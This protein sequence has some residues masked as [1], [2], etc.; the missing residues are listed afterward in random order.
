M[1][2]LPLFPAP[3]KAAR[4]S[5][6]RLARVAVLGG[7]LTGSAIMAPSAAQAGVTVAPD[8]TVT[9]TYDQNFVPSVTPGSSAPWLTAVISQIGNGVRIALTSSLETP[10]EF[11]GE[12]RF[13]IEPTLGQPISIGGNCVS[14]GNDAA[15]ALCG[16]TTFD[17]QENSANAPNAGGLLGFDFATIFPT[18]AAVRFNGFDTFAFDFTTT[19][20]V[21]LTPAS[22]LATTEPQAGGARSDVCTAVHLKG[23]TGQSAD[24]TAV[25]ISSANG[26]QCADGFIS[27]VPGPLPLLGV[28][29][30]FGYSR[31]IRTRIQG[32][33]QQATIS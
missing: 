29:A 24:S 5:W 19:G 18:S 27:K 21:A 20:S 23:I 31:K 6:A 4:L 11:F 30:A 16:I 7:A 33:R 28:A 15:N 25:G 2:G 17:Y 10:S 9:Y 14:G 13:N 1:K 3:A 8:G 22:F 12:V 26:L 32:S